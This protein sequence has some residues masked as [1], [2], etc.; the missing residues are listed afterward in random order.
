[1]TAVAYLLDEDVPAAVGQALAGIEPALR[2][3]QVGVGAAAPP[4]QTP[5]PEVLVFA[6]G[7]G[8]AVVTFDKRTM[9]GHAAAHTAAGS[10]TRGV[11]VFPDGHALSAGRIAEELVLIW[12]TSAAEEWADLVTFLPFKSPRLRG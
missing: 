8:L 3:W 2:F 12:A 1:M 10:R 4:K 7:N 6:E 9:P 11:F 5:D